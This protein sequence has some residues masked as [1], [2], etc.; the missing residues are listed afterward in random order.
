M[1]VT[2]QGEESHVPSPL[3]SIHGKSILRKSELGIEMMLREKHLINLIVTDAA[4]EN[5][6]FCHL[7]GITKNRVFRSRNY[8]P[9]VGNRL[10]QLLFLREAQRPMWGQCCEHLG[11]LERQG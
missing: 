9:Y 7:C 6:I 11:E 4:L 10:F 8:Q 5:P 2:L 3:S 1:A